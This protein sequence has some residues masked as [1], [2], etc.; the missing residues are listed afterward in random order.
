LLTL[1]WILRDRCSIVVATMSLTF[2]NAI[3]GSYR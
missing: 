1:S 2:A 3:F